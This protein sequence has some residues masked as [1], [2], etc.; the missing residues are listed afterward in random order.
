MNRRMLSPA[1]KT[2]CT[3]LV[4]VVLGMNGAALIIALR[5]GP[6]AAWNFSLRNFEESQALK[7]I[8]RQTWKMLGQIPEVSLLELLGDQPVPVQVEV[9]RYEDGI[10]FL[11]HSLALVALAVRENPPVVLEIGTFCG[12]TT[13]LLAQNLKQSIIHTVDLPAD[14]VVGRDPADALPKDDFHLIAQRTVGREYRNR[15][16]AERIVQHWAD[17]AQ[18]DF[19]L[20]SGATFF[21]IDGSHTYEYAKNDSEKCFQLCRGRGTFLWHDC[22]LSHPGVLRFLVE[23][24]EKGRNIV[25]IRGTTLAYLK[26]SS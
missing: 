11:E 14:Y 9:R 15:P 21:F 17:T 25:R 10:L 23:W 6:T 26:T 7:K 18:W 3:R 2:W 1:W 24:R 4:K 19:S 16:E 5:R 13:R 20:A 12:H 8:S 22:E